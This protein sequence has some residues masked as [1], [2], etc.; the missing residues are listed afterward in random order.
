M[1]NPE[2]LSRIQQLFKLDQFG[3]AKLYR[4]GKTAEA[5]NKLM[6]AGIGGLWKTVAGEAGLP[7]S[8][9]DWLSGCNAL[10]EARRLAQ[11]A[12]FRKR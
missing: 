8:D 2:T 12:K 1:M 10:I 4:D 6:S 11:Q 3:I 9:S 7:N 5:A